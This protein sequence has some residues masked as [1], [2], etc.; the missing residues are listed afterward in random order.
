MTDTKT[1]IVEKLREVRLDFLT[2]LEFHAKSFLEIDQK[3]KHWLT[4]TLPSFLALTSYMFSKGSTMQLPLLSVAGAVASCLF[5]SSMFFSVAL[6]SRNIESGILTPQSRKIDDL[7]YFLQDE[8]RWQE[9]AR[10]QAQ[11][12]LDAIAN[13]ESMNKA[14]GSWVRRGEISLFLATTSAIFFVGVIGFRYAAAYPDRL[15]S[16]TAVTAAIVG[17]TAGGL[18]CGIFVFVDHLCHRKEK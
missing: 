10:N 13:N 3:A 14:K 2:L 18:L 4:L 12:M 8:L 15:D 16:V 5:I 17:F 7:E 9:L 6:M 1:N 11:A